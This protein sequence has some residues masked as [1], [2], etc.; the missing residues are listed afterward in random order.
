MGITLSD[1]E[2]EYRRLVAELEETRSKEERNRLIKEIG[3]LHIRNTAKAKDNSEAHKVEDELFEDVTRE[4]DR[5]ITENPLSD[6]EQE[7]IINKIYQDPDRYTFGDKRRRWGA[8]GHEIGRPNTKK[9]APRPPT[10]ITETRK[11]GLFA[12]IKE[13]FGL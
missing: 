2:S 11:K 6:K 1:E 5:I 8:D 12:K 4:I 13:T 10:K 7:D 3:E 9:E